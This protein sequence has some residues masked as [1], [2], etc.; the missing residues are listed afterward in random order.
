MADFRGF[1]WPKENWFRLPNEWTDITAEVKSLAELKVLVYILRHTWGYM[2]QLDEPKRISMDEFANGRKRKDGSRMDKGT[3]LS[4]PSIRDG[5]K[6]AIEHG[7]ITIAKEDKSDGGRIKRWYK[8][9]MRKV[10]SSR[11]K[12][13]FYG[14]KDSLP[15]SEK[16]NRRKTLLPLDKS[17]GRGTVSGPTPTTHLLLT[18]WDKKGGAILRKI[19]VEHESDLMQPPRG[20]RVDTLAKNFFTLREQRKI[21]KQRIMANVRWLEAHYGEVHTPKLRKAQDYAI[22][23]KR[24]EEAQ[25]R[26]EQDE[27]GDWDRSTV[28]PEELPF[29]DGM[30][31]RERAADEVREWLMMN[32]LGWDTMVSPSQEQVDKALEALGRKPGEAKANQFGSQRV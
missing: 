27:E 3:G 12:E 1:V 7:F 26:W 4:L 2:E 10:S 18:D 28:E 32:D 22:H 14:D 13:S 11:G 19:L 5:I 31:E 6:R 16:D 17:K 9:C 21:P 20:V 25:Q 30:D 29:E 8:L 24:F 15:R 23:F